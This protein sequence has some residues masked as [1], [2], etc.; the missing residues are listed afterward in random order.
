MIRFMGFFTI[1]PASV[2]L[3]I[4]FFVLFALIKIESP[5]L[6]NLGRIVAV[7]LWIS[8]AL[9]LLMGLY[10]LV[11]GH[12]PVIDIVSEACKSSRR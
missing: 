11:T 2:L 6:K 12:H 3:A 4:S 5:P 8:A 7:L 10:I 1:I 9:L